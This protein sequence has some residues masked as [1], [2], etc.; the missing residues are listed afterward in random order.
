MIGL[1]GAALAFG[2]PLETSGWTEL[3][4]G[5][6][7]GTTTPIRLY[8]A[9]A[10]TPT[11]YVSAG[12]SFAVYP[13]RLS[14][15]VVDG[16]SDA[17][18]R[19]L[20][21]QTRPGP[22]ALKW[23]V[24]VVVLPIFG[25]LEVSANGAA[26]V[27]RAA[28]NEPQMK[29]LREQLAGV[30]ALIEMRTQGRV[31]VIVDV[32]VD[33]SSHRLR[34]DS[35]GLDVGGKDRDPALEAKGF[36]SLRWIRNHVEPRFNRGSWD[37]DDGKYR[38]PFDSRWVVHS[39]PTLRTEEYADSTGAIQ[40]FSFGRPG[41]W[42]RPDG[43]ARD[44]LKRWESDVASRSRL[45]GRHA[46]SADP[47][48]PLSIW[49][50]LAGARILDRIV[51][52]GRYAERPTTPVPL[53]ALLDDPKAGVE[54]DGKGP[55][56]QRDA[57]VSALPAMAE[58]IPAEA[59]PEAVVK[60][61]GRSI[62]LTAKGDLDFPKWTTGKSETSV[63]DQAVYPCGLIEQVGGGDSRVFRFPTGTRTG[64][65]RLARADRPGLL[66]L[67]V[68]ITRAEPLAIWHLSPPGLDQKFVPIYNVGTV[69]PT[70]IEIEGS[71][72]GYRLEASTPRKLALAIQAGEYFLGPSPEGA[73]VEPP[74]GDPLDVTIVEASVSSGS[75]ATPPDESTPSLAAVP[76]DA[77]LL[78]WA[79]SEDD[80]KRLPAL[81]LLSKRKVE[82]AESVVAAQVKSANP[83]IAM[84]A[85][86]ALQFNAPATAR[87]TL[88]EIIF[89]GPFDSNRESA[90]NVL[91]SD[92]SK[93][94]GPGLSV[95]LAAP[96]AITRTS[97]VRAMGR[98][99]AA[100]TQILMAGFFQDA[101][102]VVRYAA[103]H[104][105]N[106]NVDLLLK[107][108]QFV[109][110]NDPSEPVRLAALKRLLATEG[111]AM[112]EA[113]KGVRDESPWVRMDLLEF[114]GTLANPKHLIAVKNG[115][116]DSNP[117]VRAAALRSWRRFEEGPKPDDL[118]PAITDSDPRV[119][120]ELISTST[121][122]SLKLSDEVKARLKA[123]ID[124]EVRRAAGGL[125]Q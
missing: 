6:V 2:L 47:W 111:P 121:H 116:A 110:V 17:R 36:P 95:L 20:Y 77:E 34:L 93:L 71:R 87:P 44:L 43:L 86:E 18:L 49:P 73:S 64:M 106:P 50:K 38:G 109:S 65:I 124:P 35:D 114:I 4:A 122:F 3:G 42:H 16:L 102:P 46:G 119:Q 113:L 29:L 70:P 83:F 105:A 56:G 8:R 51:D 59:M 82:G 84:A 80:A 98:S 79:A 45:V 66:S 115:I 11:V 24:K 58:V 31:D 76:A 69:A 101:D 26:R 9:A 67:E 100:E 40:V 10:P 25:F 125:S 120:M 117:L 54:A 75:D 7:S 14:D 88:T 108:L 52:P 91:D 74:R 48:T 21:S 90:A 15:I 22:D 12:R 37:A 123:S 1:I 30:E 13:D 104:A 5:T 55:S 107:R 32:E 61:D 72:A 53:P 81:V 85:A 39:G 23:R 63:D 92:G 28:I 19:E 99:G 96:N 27:R 89:T 78:Q 112:N 41:V 118:L 33:S 103:V 57:E 60:A 62:A 94:A 97:A 68:S